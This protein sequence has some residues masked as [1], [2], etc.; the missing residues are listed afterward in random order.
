MRRLKTMPELWVSVLVLGTVFSSLGVTVSEMA[1]AEETDSPS[2][3][4]SSVTQAPANQPAPAQPAKPKL[5]PPFFEEERS[6]DLG[7]SQSFM[8]DALFGLPDPGAGGGTGTDFNP[9]VRT[10][11]ARQRSFGIFEQLP[12]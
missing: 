7:F 2:P 9:L 3:A 1:L 6:F 10:P 8:T 5:K 4:E 11:A 12:R